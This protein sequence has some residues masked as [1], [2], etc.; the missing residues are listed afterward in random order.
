MRHIS[1]I[2]NGQNLGYIYSVS[3]KYGR[4]S[5]T[6]DI[7]KAKTYKTDDLAFGEID[8]LAAMSFGRN[9]VFMVV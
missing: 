4:Y 1:V 6:G 2:Q 3:Y 5:L 7:R 8:K 9:V